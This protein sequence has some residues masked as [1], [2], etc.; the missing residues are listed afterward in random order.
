VFTEIPL[1]I[2]CDPE[3]GF[4]CLSGGRKWPQ[5]DNRSAEDYGGDEQLSFLL[6]FQIS[7]AKISPI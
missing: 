2:P 5:V 3:S 6:R 4:R 7:W 1:L